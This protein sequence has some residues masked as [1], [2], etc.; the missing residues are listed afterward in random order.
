MLASSFHVWCAACIALPSSISHWILSS[1]CLSLWLHL[2]GPWENLE[3]VDLLSPLECLCTCRRCRPQE[4]SE[5]VWIGS[6][7]CRFARAG[8]IPVVLWGRQVPNRS[9]NLAYAMSKLQ[10]S[11]K[12]WLQGRE[13]RVSIG[14]W[15][16]CLR[17]G[18]TLRFCPPSSLS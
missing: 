17:S 3:I 5:V 2:R 9:A 1:H 18:S 4:G 7:S 10:H 8:R 6:L 13:L 11:W 15:R 12:Q 14:N 16:L